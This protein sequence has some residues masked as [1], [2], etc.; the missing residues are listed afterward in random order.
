MH[1]VIVV[2]HVLIDLIFLVV[3]VLGGRIDELELPAEQ[4]I[5]GDD[6]RLIAHSD[7][8]THIEIF[9]NVPQLLGVSETQ[10]V[11]E[12]VRDLIGIHDGYGELIVLFRPL[13][14]GD[15]IF[16]L[17]SVR[18]DHFKEG[19]HS[20]GTGVGHQGRHHVA[21]LVE[22]AVG[23]DLGQVVRRVD[24]IDDGRHGID[25][26]DHAHIVL[27]L[28]G[29][30]VQIIHET[31]QVIVGDRV[32]KRGDILLFPQEIPLGLVLRFG[33]H[34][35]NSAGQVACLRIDGQ[36]VAVHGL[37]LDLVDIIL[38][39]RRQRK[40]QRDA[41]DTDGTREGSQESAS[42]LGHQVI[43]TQTEGRRQGHRRFAQI[44]VNSGLLALDR[45]RVGVAYDL[46]VLETH[47]AV[48]ILIGKFGVV[49]DHDDKTI[50]GHF[51]QEVHDL[52]GSLGI[53][54]AGGLVRK[55]DLGVV[56]ERSRD[57]DALH[58]SA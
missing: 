15:G 18:F 36:R 19:R 6:H 43:E 24:R 54:S 29:M 25:V 41:D 12:K 1:V 49:S 46:S 14:V 48:G 39:T 52:N 23:M 35:Q 55:Q 30:G 9:D 22:T 11:E 45:E 32:R 53:Q 17:H 31:L 16:F 47:G 2:R 38:E 3:L 50:R 8:L 5:V 44:L 42:L 28:L 26:L 57:R 37:F 58:L 20:A 33:P 7:L 34:G 13:S 56:D 27:I 51:F 4:L 21:L 40:D 10:R